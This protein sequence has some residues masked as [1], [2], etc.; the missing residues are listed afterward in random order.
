MF[1]QKSQILD[2]DRCSSYE[3]LVI[4][5]GPAGA[6]AA[7]CIARLGWKVALLEATAGDIARYGETLPPECNPLL[8]SLGLW[9]AFQRS[10]PLESPGIVSYWGQ[11]TPAQQDFL[12]NAHGTGWHVDRVRF[13]AEL[14]AE[15]VRA[16]V[17]I[18]RGARV[19]SIIRQGG[20]WRCSGI[21]ARFVVDATGRNGLRLGS[22]APREI[23]GNL[24][25]LVRRLSHPSGRPSDLRTQIVAVPSGWWY[26][27]PVPAGDSVAMFFTN[28]DGYGDARRLAPRE[29]V[30][31]APVI[32]TLISSAPILESRWISASSSLRKSL[33]GDGWI[34]VGDS[35]SSYD[36]ISGQGIHKAIRHAGR[37]AESVDAALR[38]QPQWAEAYE[39]RIR[40]EFG[41]YSRQRHT[42]YAMESRWPRSSFWSAFQR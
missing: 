24:L 40:R 20:W 29:C 16:G 35:A 28:F 2:R 8:R 33:C 18:L 3:V 25:V 37:A 31:T 17:T 15:A 34:A 11:G 10:A 42:Y 1:A 39:S 9:D 32:A 30:Q 19:A 6:V 13:D 36:P 7:L 14:C 4:G 26:W 41:D 23:D 12:Q 5:G 38:G 27:A 22:A 21:T